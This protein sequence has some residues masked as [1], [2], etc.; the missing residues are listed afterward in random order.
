MIPK[1]INTAN[2]HNINISKRVKLGK[3]HTC[4]FSVDF[5]LFQNTK[6]KV[7]YREVAQQLKALVLVEDLILVPRTHMVAYTHL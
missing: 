4:H 5:K 7:G 1:K 3:G 2:K 6:F